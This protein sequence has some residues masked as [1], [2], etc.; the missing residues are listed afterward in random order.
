MTQRTVYTGDQFRF[1][2]VRPTLVTLRLWSRA[3]EELILGT[4]AQETHLGAMGRRQR[5]GGPALGILQM[6]GPTHDAVWTW[7]KRHRP[8]IALG[9]IDLVSPMARVPLLLV[10]DDRYAVAMGRAL[11]LSIPFPIPEAENLEGQARYYK[12]WW[13]GPGKA[14]PEQYRENYQRLVRPEAA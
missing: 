9:I 7:L 11:Y 6:E 12:K 14:T 4:A 10:T 2:V 5:G 13:N 8:N 3:A 1:E